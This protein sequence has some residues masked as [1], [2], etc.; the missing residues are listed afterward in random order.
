[1]PWVSHP[2][3]GNDWGISHR[4]QASK[5]HVVWS[6]AVQGCHQ[7][8]NLFHYPSSSGATSSVSLSF[9]LFS[10][11]TLRR[12]KTSFVLEPSQLPP[13]WHLWPLNPH[14]FYTSPSKTKCPSLS[15]PKCSISGEDI[16]LAPFGPLTSSSPIRYD[17]G[18]ESCSTH[19]ATLI[20][21]VEG[22]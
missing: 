10:T 13:K 21:L 2:V 16:W 18:V 3:A 5:V 19:T 4:L 11:F 20:Y 8:S 22:E 7:K 6:P 15:W 9:S 14:N 17:Q 12:G 1:M